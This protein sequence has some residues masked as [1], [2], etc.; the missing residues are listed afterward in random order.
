MA[1]VVVVV[2]VVAAAMVAVAVDLLAVSA[3]S[4]TVKQQDVSAS[5]IFRLSARVK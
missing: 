1:P 5:C 4:I 3:G 2:V